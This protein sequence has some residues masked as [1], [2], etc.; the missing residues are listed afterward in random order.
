[1][2]FTE[3]NGRPIPKPERGDFTTDA[4]YVRAFHDYK[5]RIEALSWVAFDDQFRKA[6]R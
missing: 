5:R 3:E 6:M 4:E 1:V 2:I